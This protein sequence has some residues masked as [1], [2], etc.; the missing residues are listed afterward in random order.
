MARLFRRSALGIVLA[1]ALVLAVGW[2]AG[3]RPLSLLLDRIHTV[4]TESK[5]IE[6][7]GLEDISGGMLRIS[8]LQFNTATP[9]YHPY[10]K[11]EIDRAGQFVIQIP[12]QT[13]ALGRIEKSL[14][15]DSGPLLR[16]GA[17]DRATFRIE[18][19]LLSWPTPLAMN[20]MTG[21]SPSWKRNTYYRLTW[22]KTEGGQIEMVWRYEQYFYD[23]WAS[24]F[25]T[26]EGATGLIRVDIR[27]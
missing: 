15:K 27:P 6:R 25:M 1:L 23:R 20:F 17:G 14:G 5:P 11:M 22:Q 24:G 8:D 16:P 18:H 10:L 7:L 3:A 13:I 4:T 9:D 26:R 2:V 12:G 19:S 21:H